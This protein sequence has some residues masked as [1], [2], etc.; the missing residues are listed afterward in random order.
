MDSIDM[1]NGIKAPVIEVKPKIH[2]NFA[3]LEKSRRIDECLSV[4]P[5][6]PS[7]FKF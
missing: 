1:L 3:G 4:G 6:S 5:V 2:D 7:Y